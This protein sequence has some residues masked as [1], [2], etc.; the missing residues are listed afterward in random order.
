MTVLL[1]L[2]FFILFLTID[3]F[4][5]RS[6][7]I[8]ASPA[9]ARSILATLVNGFNLPRNLFFHPGH[10]WA[11]AESPSLVRVGMDDFAS[12]LVGK[13]DSIELPNRDTWIRQGQKFATLVRDGK[14]VNLMSPIEGSITDINTAAIRNPEILKDP[15]NEGWLMKVNSPDLKTSLRNLFNGTMARAWIEEAA[16]R[17]NPTMAYALAQDGGEAVD[18]ITVMLGKEWEPT[19]K[20]FLLN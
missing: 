2:L 12:K 8:V 17:L 20:E 16:V 19:V 10:T 7:I 9:P 6:K 18:D 14:S 15:Y 13:I 3:Y 1:V 4:K 5:S 11:L